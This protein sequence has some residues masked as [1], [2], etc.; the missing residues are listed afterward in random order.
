MG[1]LCIG[2]AADHG[3]FLP[4]EKAL[5]LGYAQTTAVALQKLLLR[6]NL[7]KN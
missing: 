4:D 6:E 7:E 2:R 1:I 5:L 3:G